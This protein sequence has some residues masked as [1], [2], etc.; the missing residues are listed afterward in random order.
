M[1]I[2]TRILLI[3]GIVFLTG[4]S[5]GVVGWIGFQEHFRLLAH[6]L[7]KEDVQNQFQAKKDSNNQ[8]MQDRSVIETKHEAKLFIGE[9]QGGLTGLEN[10]DL[11]EE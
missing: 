3:G 2:G 6:S 7:Q 5:I 9:L 8:K 10:D 4:G 1:K 11:P